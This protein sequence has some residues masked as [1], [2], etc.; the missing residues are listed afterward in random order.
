MTPRIQ[1]DTTAG[2]AAA[3]RGRALALLIAGLLALLAADHM[4][5]TPGELPRTP[6]PKLGETAPRNVDVRGARGW[7][8]SGPVTP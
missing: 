5:G 2:R 1:P 8:R 3:H 6:D 4:G 7:S